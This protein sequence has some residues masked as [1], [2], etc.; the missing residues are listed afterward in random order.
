VLGA[1]LG[2]LVLGNRNAVLLGNT[3]QVSGVLLLLIPAHITVYSGL[4]FF[5][6][7]QG[8]SIA[9]LRSNYA[10][11]YLRKQQLLPSALLLFYNASNLGA[12][13]APILIGMIGIIYN[14]WASIIAVGIIVLLSTLFFVFSKPIPSPTR[15][16]RIPLPDRPKIIQLFG[17]IGLI[18]LFLT[19]FFSSDLDIKALGTFEDLS[20]IHHAWGFLI[21]L[22]LSIG[23]SI[24]WRYRYPSTL[25][26]LLVTF[27]LGALVYLLLFLLTDSS[28]GAS[29]IQYIYLLPILF[30][31]LAHLHIAPLID[32]YLTTSVPSKYLS[33][34][35]LSTDMLMYIIT[36]L[37][38][39]LLGF[40]NSQSVFL[41]VG[42]G[43]FLVVIV[44]LG[45]VRKRTINL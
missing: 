34:A 39:F 28:V 5:I 27:V 20:G 8:M 31:Q 6:V 4:G 17:L 40:I 16:E 25:S 22:L 32:E 15:Q 41:W 14:W 7:G 24:F 42:L 38:A 19:L 33:I 35:M 1:F 26:K 2:D 44:F 9:N 13:I 21:F 23:F 43:I 37:G 11:L 30:M 29:G 3:L 45:I 18:G 12:F 10:R 36:G